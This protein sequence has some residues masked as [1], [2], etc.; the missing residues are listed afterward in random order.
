MRSPLEID[1]RFPFTERDTLEARARIESDL[2]YVAKRAHAA[3]EH[4]VALVLTGGFS[5]GEGTVR[6]GAPV[7]DYDLLAI[8]ARPGGDGRYRELAAKLSEDVGLEVDIMPVWRARLPHVGRKLFW[9]DARLGGRVISGDP[10]ALARLPDFGA[11]EIPRGEIARLLGNRAA[12]MLLSIP[13]EGEAPDPH[14]RDLQATKAVIAALD[15]TLLHRGLYAARLRD[16]LA[17]SAGHPHHGA[18]T[19]AVEW[20]LR[21]SHPLPSDWWERARDVLL[22][23]VDKTHAR[24]THDGLAEHA[25]HLLRARRI[26]ISPSQSVRRTA[27]DLLS[28]STWP[29]GPAMLSRGETWAVAKRG[30]FAARART[31]Q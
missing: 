5:R 29:A 25:L 14:Q 15:A 30:F 6:D 16:R 2:A 28:V 4:L 1:L 8:R 23:A 10:R 20:K 18:F 12:G 21:P 19:T 22:S 3:D 17:L 27:W 13:A 24:D 9:L 11:R 31:L 26:A 7:N